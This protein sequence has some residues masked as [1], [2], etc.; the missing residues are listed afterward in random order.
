MA[1]SSNNNNNTTTTGAMTAPPF[2]FSAGAPA[3]PPPF[4]PR[5]LA[6]T[7]PMRPPARSRPQLQEDLARSAGRWVH[8]YVTRKVPAPREFSDNLE[9]IFLSL[10]MFLSPRNNHNTL[11]RTR[12]LFCEPEDPARITRKK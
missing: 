7:L 10:S 12:R 4:L 3:Q 1:S 6:L 9:A 8:D 11:S 2:N 5:S